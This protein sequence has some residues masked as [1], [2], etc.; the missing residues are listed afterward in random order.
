MFQYLTPSTLEEMYKDLDESRLL[1][2]EEV[3]KENLIIKSAE[4]HKLTNLIQQIDKQ[5][6][7]L[8]GEALWVKMAMKDVD[9]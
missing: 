1:L 7:A 2:L 8:A 6:E 9:V 3:N 5:Y 4:Y